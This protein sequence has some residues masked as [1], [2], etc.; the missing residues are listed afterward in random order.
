[1]A[2]KGVYPQ[3][4]SMSA[5]DFFRREPEGV[6][7]ARAKGVGA[8]AHR[9]PVV[10]FCVG[11][12]IY[13]SVLGDSMQSPLCFFLQIYSGHAAAYSVHGATTESIPSQALRRPASRRKKTQT[14]LSSRYVHAQGFR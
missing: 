1:M 12:V 8:G 13:S 2:V 7:S 11:H 4:V 10:F 6:F 14:A 3:H 5:V 9:V